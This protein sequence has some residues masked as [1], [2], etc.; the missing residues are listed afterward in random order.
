MEFKY[1]CPGHAVGKRILNSY[2]VC[3]DDI[4][5]FVQMFSHNGMSFTFDLS[6]L[7]KVLGLK[8]S[9]GTPCSWTI[10]KTGTTSD[11]IRDLYYVGCKNKNKVVYLHV[12]WKGSDECRPY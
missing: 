1:S 10:Y 12:S 3:K 9:Y 5:E 2:N 7:D 11:K 4:G 6:D 8:T